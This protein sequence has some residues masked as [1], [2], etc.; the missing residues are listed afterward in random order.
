MTNT[1]VSKCDMS[2]SC[3]G[4]T[5]VWCYQGGLWPLRRRGPDWRWAQWR[6]QERGGAAG[7][8][9]GPAR[10]CSNPPRQP[11]NYWWK[12]SALKYNSIESFDSLLNKRALSSERWRELS[13]VL[14]TFYVND[15]LLNWGPHP[16]KI[17]MKTFNCVKLMILLEWY[18]LFLYCII[19]SL[20]M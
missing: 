7:R 18:V 6:N 9:L 8:G 13:C 10:T 15:C 2:R 5:W 4:V 12:S 16:H 17:N 3:P 19:V 1:T 11:L 14:L 20:C